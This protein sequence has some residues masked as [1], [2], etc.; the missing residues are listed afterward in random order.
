[1]KIFSKLLFVFLL[2][3]ILFSGCSMHE[4][5]WSE[6]TCTTLKT[7]NICDATEGELLSHTFKPA[8][9]SNPKTCEVCGKTDGDALG[10]DNSNVTCTTDAPCIRCNQIINAPGHKWSSATCTESQKC[11]VCN[12]LT[13]QALGHTTSNGVCTRCGYEIYETVT[14]K[15]DDVISNISIGDGVYRIHFTH[16]GRSNFSI[17]AYDSNGDRDLLVNDIGKYDGYVFFD[18][19]SPYSFEITA[20]GTWTYTIEKLSKT[21]ETSFSGRG[22]FV[23][24]I[25]SLS[26]KTWQFTHNGKSNFS[27]WVYTNDGRDLLVNEIGNYDGKK[28]ID[29]SVGDNAFFVIHADGNWSINPVS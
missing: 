17:W 28:I 12:E 20:D 1:M 3:T 14:G 27:I 26:K 2:S 9:C 25:C 29:F 24:P 5:E 11:T 23:T 4:H 22:D 18:G 19:I 21:S 15:G 16:S 10:H 7:C 8:T 13:G 6:A